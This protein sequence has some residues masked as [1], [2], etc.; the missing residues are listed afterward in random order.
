MSDT[1]Q[2]ERW[3]YCRVV[4]EDGAPA[5]ETKWMVDEERDEARWADL[6]AP[7]WLIVGPYEDRELLT[8]LAPFAADALQACL[9]AYDE[10]Q[11]PDEEVLMRR[12]A[13][14]LARPLNAA[15]TIARQAATLAAANA[16]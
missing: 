9:D 8:A 3:L 15:L 1:G 6:D 2:D 7:E 4:E 12:Y 14:L 5:L 11:P 16:A 10:E 13:A